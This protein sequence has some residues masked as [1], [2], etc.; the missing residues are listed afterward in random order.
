MLIRFPL[1]GLVEFFLFLFI[2]QVLVIVF[3]VS[4]A[5]VLPCVRQYVEA[6]LV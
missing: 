3:I 2:G 4:I 1:Q 5:L 6:Q